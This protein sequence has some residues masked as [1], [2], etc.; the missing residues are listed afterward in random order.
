LGRGFKA[1][2]RVCFE[3]AKIGADLDCDG[4]Q[5]SNVYGAVTIE[6]NNAEIQGSV[7]FTRRPRRRRRLAE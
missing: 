6:A 5:F 2:G 4:G 3:D 7:F 1:N